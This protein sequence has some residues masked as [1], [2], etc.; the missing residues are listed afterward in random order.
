MD[1]WSAT[2]IL[3]LIMDPLGNLP[4]FI[5]ILKTVSPERRKIILIREL[6][7]ALVF[8]LLFLFAGQ[9]VLSFMG[10]EESAVGIAGSVVLMI[11]AVRM[12]FPAARNPASSDDPVA[13]EE[14][15]IVPLAI[16]LI[17]GPS[18]M[19]TAMLLSKKNPDNYLEIT[20]AM[21]IAWFANSVILMCSGSLMHILGKRGLVALE[22]LM[23]MVLVM[24]AIQMLLDG[25]KQYI[26]VLHF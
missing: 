19:A 1:I 24:L 2:I 15:F 16:P 4:V 7:I 14:P 11:I 6:C 8:M 18:L 9:S 10:L 26:S 22:R 23:G 12:I 3:F 21:I 13:D 17:A 5:S 25:I 20:I